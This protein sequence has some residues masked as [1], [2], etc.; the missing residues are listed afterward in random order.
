MNIDE[1]SVK[2]KIGQRF[3]FGINSDNIDDIIYLI[4][5]YYIG[6]VILYKKNYSTYNEMLSVIKKLKEANRKNKIPLFITIDQE[7]GLV[8]RF[9]KEIDNLK[10]I[11]DISK[12]SKELVGKSALVIAKVLNQSGINM[13][14]APVLDIYN[15]SSSKALYN[16]CFCGDVNDVCNYSKVYIKEFDKNNV[17]TVCKHFPGHGITRLDSHFFVPYIYNYKKILNNHILPF[18]SAID[19]GADVLMVGHLVI[20]K[21]TGMVP[22]SISKKFIN[23]Y[24]RNELNYSG[25]VMS[26]EVNMLSRNIFYK[27]NYIKKVVNSGTDIVL[28]KIKNRMDAIKIIDKAIHVVKEEELDKNVERIIKVKNKYKITDDINFKGCDVK[29]VNKEINKINSKVII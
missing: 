27:F 6:G 29:E 25:I 5:N 3:I 21:L 4:K 17:I 20:H 26:D 13:N 12:T 14:L 23:N 15:N 10:N 8:N 28:V 22:A 24:L 7:G 9:P 2:E 19:N 16:R 18:K 11:Y 1:L